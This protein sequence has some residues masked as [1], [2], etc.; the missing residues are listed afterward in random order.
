M[1]K[2]TIAAS[3]YTLAIECDPATGVVAMSGISYPADAAEFFEPVF[4]WMGEY[5][6]QSLG[7][8]RLELRIDYLNTSS[9]KCLFDLIDRA[10]GY[11][12][13]GAEVA[14]DWYYK[15]G[16]D[17]IKETGLE[18]KEEMVLPFEIIPY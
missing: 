10:E 12:K 11:F 15:A 7:P 13:S 3:K 1:D 14:I 9:T 18:F 6:A 5:I 16:D 17:D 2:L 4:D 8:L